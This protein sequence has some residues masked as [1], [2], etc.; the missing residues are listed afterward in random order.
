MARLLG[1]PAGKHW[2]WMNPY[3]LTL[4]SGR[5]DDVSRQTWEFDTNDLHLY[6]LPISTKSTRK[7]IG[8]VLRHYLACW[9][10]LKTS[11]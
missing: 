10:P 3:P 9:E 4:M 5:K 1:N 11:C 2:I 7:L 8:N 6:I